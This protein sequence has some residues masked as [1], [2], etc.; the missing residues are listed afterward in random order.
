MNTTNQTTPQNDT[1]LK[2]LVHTLRQV[3]KEPYF[4]DKTVLIPDGFIHEGLL[5]GDYLIKDLLH[6]IADMIEE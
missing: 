6:I 3:S 2:D 1:K 4:K 5:P